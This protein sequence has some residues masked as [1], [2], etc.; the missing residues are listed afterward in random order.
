M[1]LLLKYDSSDTSN[2]NN[3]EDVGINEGNNT[4]IDDNKS[5]EIVKEQQEMILNKE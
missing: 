1:E 4:N 2:N 3:N 5:T